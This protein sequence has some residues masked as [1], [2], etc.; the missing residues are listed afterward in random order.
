MKKEVMAVLLSGVVMAGL[1]GCSEAQENGNEDVTIAKYVEEGE[2]ETQSDI[3]LLDSSK[4]DKIL[5]E[6]GLKASDFLSCLGEKISDDDTLTLEHYE[7]YCEEPLVLRVQARDFNKREEYADEYFYVSQNGFL[8]EVDGEWYEIR[9]N[10]AYKEGDVSCDS[11]SISTNF[12]TK[13]YFYL[14]IC[15][16]EETVKTWDEL[17]E[18]ADIHLTNE[19]MEDYFVEYTMNDMD[20][21]AQVI[22]DTDTGSGLLIYYYVT[23][24]DR[25]FSTM[26]YVVRQQ[27]SGAEFFEDIDRYTGEEFLQEIF[28]LEKFELD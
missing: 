24:G 25:Q 1:C 14:Y 23:V 6:K 17:K 28:T 5:E 12:T 10:D 4:A 11:E 19:Y 8:L 3:E 18:T 21:F 15:R 27:G 13:Q 20:V 26:T 7:V 9:I 22:F 2:N 16:F